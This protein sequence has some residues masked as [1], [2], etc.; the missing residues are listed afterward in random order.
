VS[1]ER[2][3]LQQARSA[4]ASERPDLAIA[5][6]TQSFERLSADA[7]AAASA[8]DLA[9]AAGGYLLANSFYDRA[10]SHAP[11]LAGVRFNRAATARFLGDLESAEKDY[12]LVIDSDPTDTEAWLNRSHLRRQTSAHNHISQI[13]AALEGKLSAWHD[14]MRLLYALAKERE[15]LG[16]VYQAF[17]A[18]DAATTL[19]RRHLDYDIEDDLAALA[20]I[21]STFASSTLALMG[22]GFSGAAPIFV[23]G[24]PR[25]GT[26]L[27]ERILEAHPDVVSG[28]EM[29]AFSQAL[30]RCAKSNGFQG[31][32]KHALIPFSKTL[33]P[34]DLGEC[35]HALASAGRKPVPHII[36]K[37]PLNYLYI[38]LIAKALPH[39][40]IIHVHKPPLAVGWGM[41]KTLFVQGYPFSYDQVE[42]GRYIAAFHSLMEHWSR[43][44]PGRIHHVLYDDL[45]RDPITSIRELV[46]ACGLD[47]HEDC[48]SPHKGST[49]NTSHS[50]AQIREPIHTRGLSGWRDFTPYLEPMRKAMLAEGLATE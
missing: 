14:R 50:A 7:R 13:E 6:L 47:W 21:R 27:V 28:G 22:K 42:L 43:E 31:G 36:D 30:E 3:V 44:L 32:G 46:A 48:L 45:V 23:L 10:L 34:A 9:S 37:L 25:S 38:G 19:R 24:L 26:T 12:D 16:Q 33:D 18:L 4:L 15:D 5:F 2:A 40:R 20:A 11:G 41:L 1:T 17:A 29:S 8:G 49:A 39:A 35:Y